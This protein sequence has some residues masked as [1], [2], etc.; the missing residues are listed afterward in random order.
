MRDRVAAATQH[1]GARTAVDAFA[2][3]VLSIQHVTIA[4]CITRVLLLRLSRDSTF[5]ASSG[6]ST[7]D[8]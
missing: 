7:V 1:H 6:L 5:S 3:T 2:F 4:P 8:R